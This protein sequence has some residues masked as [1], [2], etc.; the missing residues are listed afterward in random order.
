[1]ISSYSSYN[2]ER[3]CL[4]FYKSSFYKTLQIMYA[5]LICN[6]SIY[7]S[8]TMPKRKYSFDKRILFCIMYIDCLTQFL[9][10]EAPIIFDL[11]Q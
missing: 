5:A 2:W 11:E 9:S 6:M 8:W 10:I 3:K 4:M 7:Y 1:M